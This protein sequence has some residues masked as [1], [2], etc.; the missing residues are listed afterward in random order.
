[1]IPQ[2]AGTMPRSTP[3]RG[4]I[5][6]LVR[7]KKYALP[8]LPLAALHPLL[9]GSLVAACLDAARFNPG[10]LA[11]TPDAQPGPAGIA[12]ELETNRVASLRQGE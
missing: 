3:V 9:G 8:L 10:K 12:R 4:V 6:S 5:E 11:A 2:V 7:S 1:V